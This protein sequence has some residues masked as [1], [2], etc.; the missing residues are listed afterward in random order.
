MNFYQYVLYAMM[1]PF[2]TWD[3]E[4]MRENIFY[5]E[6][7]LQMTLNYEKTQR[8]ILVSFFRHFGRENQ[9]S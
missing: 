2:D 4:S 1:V 8:I 7:D 5:E 6:F 9:N 3:M